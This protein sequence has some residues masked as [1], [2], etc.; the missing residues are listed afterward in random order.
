MDNHGARP[1][2]RFKAKIATASASVSSANETD[3]SESPD[4]NEQASQ[5]KHKPKYPP[6]L[7]EWL[8]ELRQCESGGDYQIDTGNG[9]YGAYQFSEATWDTL[10]TG[11]ATASDAPPAVQDAAIIENTNRSDGGLATQNPGCYEA[12]GLS[13]FPPK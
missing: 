2:I 3:Q 4:H 8:Y 13:Q 9:Y 7:E 11:Y 6:A 1:R 12:E 10:N 5:P